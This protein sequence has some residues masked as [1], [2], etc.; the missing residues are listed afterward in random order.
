MKRP[1]SSEHLIYLLLN[2]KIFK[3]CLYV[4]RIRHDKYSDKMKSIK[5]KQEQDIT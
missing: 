3:D 2:C 4:K 1:P 5:V